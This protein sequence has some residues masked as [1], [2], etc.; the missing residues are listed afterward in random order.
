MR[1]EEGN[2]RVASWPEALEAAARGL[3]AARDAKGVGVLVGGRVS[4]ED[5]YA[6]SKFTRIA[7]QTNDID[8][9]ARPA[10]G[11]GG[12]V[13][14]QPRRGH[15]AR[16][17]AR[18]PTPTSSGPGRSSSSASSPRTSPRS[19]SCG[20]ARPSA[21]TRPPCT[22]SRRSPRAGWTSSAARWSRRLPAPRPR[23]SRR[24]P[25]APTTA[26]TRAW[27]P[28]L[29][30]WPARAPCCS[31]ASGWPASPERCPRPRPWRPPAGPAWRGSRAGPV[32]GARWRPAPLPEPA[33]RRP[34]GHRVRR[35]RR[36][37]RGLG[38]RRPARPRGPR[39]RARS[40]PP[41]APAS[42]AGCWS[43]GST[44]PTWRST[45]EVLDALTRTFVVSLEVRDERGHRA[46]RRRAAGGR[47]PGEG[48]HVRQLGGPGP[49]LRGRAGDQ[50][51]ERP[52]GAGPARRRDGGAPRAA[53]HRLRPRRHA[54]ARP[55]AGS[56]RRGPDHAG[57]GGP[58]AAATAR[59]SS[60]PGT[61]CWTPAACRTAS[62]SSPAPRPRSRALLSAATATAV[63]VS[64]GDLLT[65]ASGTGRITLPV[66]VTE[67][68]DHVVW[69][70]TCSPGSTVRA[71]LGVDAGAVV[72]ITKGGA[73]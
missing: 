33:A 57:R 17:A 7:L 26:P 34:S 24:W 36:G 48:R 51:H 35:P 52:P 56:T 23:S 3:A 41:P 70:P 4:A 62:R 31:W 58:A 5:A 72:S 46:R 22:P 50:R 10:L 73:A 8:F 2:L 14:R 18:S 59:R 1:D 39:H 19:C 12:G 6:Y 28:R 49:D 71:S 15:R 63:G 69:L 55:L 61:T 68:A 53:H 42:W 60:P 13:P 64:E 11:R 44:R 27:P 67:M 38:R 54:R 20:C 43:A 25:T 29:R 30:R 9:R 40:S 16:T 37:R 21:R 32:S 45:A 65:V 47:A 66:A